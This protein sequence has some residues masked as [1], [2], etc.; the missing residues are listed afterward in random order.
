MPRGELPACSSTGCVCGEGGVLS[1]PFTLK[2]RPRCST[3]RTLAGSP[4]WPVRSS[5][6]SVQGIGFDP[7]HISYVIP[8]T[9]DSVV[10]DYL[11][12]TVMSALSAILP[13]LEQHIR[14][15]E[16]RRIAEGLLRR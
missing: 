9:Y 6:S 15:D 13:D 16:R 3:S 4:T 12:A 1:G 5:H 11:A 14:D 2:N 10:H 8:R 7:G